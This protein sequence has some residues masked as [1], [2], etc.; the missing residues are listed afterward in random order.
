MLCAQ[1]NWAV[2]N[3][4]VWDGVSNYNMC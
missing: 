4:I 2:N 3:N 1:K